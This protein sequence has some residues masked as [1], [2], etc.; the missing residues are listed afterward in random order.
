[1]EKIH[2][3]A[4]LELVLKNCSTIMHETNRMDATQLMTD[5]LVILR[6]LSLLLQSHRNN[7]FPLSIELLEVDEV[8]FDWPEVKISTQQPSLHFIR[9]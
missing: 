8:T 5:I 4:S 6:D 2:T 1:M 9:V 3:E 7:F